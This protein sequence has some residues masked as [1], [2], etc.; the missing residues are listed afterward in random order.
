MNIQEFAKLEPG[1]KIENVGIGGTSTGRITK[2]DNDGVHV[3]WGDNENAMP[4]FYSGQGTAWFHWSK[5]QDDA[6]TG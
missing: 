3:A 6:A 2:I 4:F 1:D 5:V